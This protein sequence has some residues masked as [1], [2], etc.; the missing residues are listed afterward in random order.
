M[1]NTSSEDLYSEVNWI[2]VG[3]LDHKGY[4][5][6]LLPMKKDNSPIYLYTLT[7]DE[8]NKNYGIVADDDKLTKKLKSD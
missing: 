2:R 7:Y 6:L 1:P 8:K 3:H 4:P 5:H